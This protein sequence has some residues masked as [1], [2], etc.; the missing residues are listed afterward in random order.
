MIMID[1]YPAES[2]LLKFRTS[3]TY[4]NSIMDFDSTP[5]IIII[6]ILKFL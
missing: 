4:D 1:I 2:S 5:L 6:L 3:Q